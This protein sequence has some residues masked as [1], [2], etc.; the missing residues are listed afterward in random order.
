MGI[1]KAV[2]CF[3]HNAMDYACRS[4]KDRP[5]VNL[6]WGDSVQDVSEKK[7]ILLNRLE[8]VLVIC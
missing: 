7:N 3:K 6:N 5:K 1:R 4:M 8:I 2:E